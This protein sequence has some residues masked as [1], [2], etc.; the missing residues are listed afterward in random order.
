MSYFGGVYRPFIP[1]NT[2]INSNKRSWI[3]DIIFGRKLMDISELEFDNYNT[4]NVYIPRCGS[5]NDSTYSK[6][7]T[8]VLSH[9][10]H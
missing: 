3:G 7:T 6:P 2:D 10:Q 5:Y 4:K 1:I 9:W 8:K